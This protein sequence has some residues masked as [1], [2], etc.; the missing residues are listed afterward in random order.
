M[1]MR[2]P[3]VEETDHPW[4]GFSFLFF[5]LTFRVFGFTTFGT[6]GTFRPGSTCEGASLPNAE[7]GRGIPS[8]KTRKVKVTFA[9]QRLGYGLTNSV[10]GIFGMVLR[11]VDVWAK[12]KLG[13]DYVSID[14]LVAG[15]A[16]S[17]ALTWRI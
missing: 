17:C 12:T 11:P 3:R 6:V 15:P 4:F 9:L 10:S 13:G 16:A 5:F 14:A 8:D 2:Q 1:H 7:G